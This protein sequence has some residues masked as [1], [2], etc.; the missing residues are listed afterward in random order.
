MTEHRHELFHGPAFRQLRSFPRESRGVAPSAGSPGTIRAEPAHGCRPWHEG[1]WRAACV[2]LSVP[3]LEALSGRYAAPGTRR[4][5]EG[6]SLP[7]E[8]WRGQTGEKGG[9]NEP[10]CREP[11][12]VTAR[13][14]LWSGCGTGRKGIAGAGVPRVGDELVLGR[15][16]KHGDQP[17]AA[18]RAAACLVDAATHG[19]I[20]GTRS[21]AP[22]PGRRSAGPFSTSWW[23]VRAQPILRPDARVTGASSSGSDC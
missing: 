8:R 9:C 7:V 15:L 13:R 21:R 14:W 4:R 11:A 2:C 1:R 10:D 6:N 20:L 22:R 12:V 5:Q 18:A 17:P 16:G 3:G 23:W 19:E